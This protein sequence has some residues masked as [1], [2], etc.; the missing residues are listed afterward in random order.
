MEKVVLVKAYF[1]PVGKNVSVKVPTGEK[2][3]GLFGGQKEVMKKEIQWQQTGYSESEIDSQRLVN[4]L[5]E[6]IN[7]LNQ[8]GYE[9]KDIIPII[10]GGFDYKYQAQGISSSRRVLSE[11]EKVT[12]GASFGYGYGFSYTDSLIVI[13]N[14]VTT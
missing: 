11:T 5:Q 7:D 13:A 2:K 14:R 6:T 10:S 1:A 12:G 8:N 3:Q 4:D 9:V